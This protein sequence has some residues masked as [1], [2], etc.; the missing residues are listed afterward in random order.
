LKEARGGAKFAA[1]AHRLPHV[2]I[3]TTYRNMDAPRT[4]SRTRASFRTLETAL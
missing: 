4:P 2:V 1:A 3:F